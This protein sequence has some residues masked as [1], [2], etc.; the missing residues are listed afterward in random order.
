MEKHG[1]KVP[2]S[3]AHAPFFETF[4]SVQWQYFKDHPER[5][6]SFNSFM[7]GQ[8]QGRTCWLDIYPAE[9]RLIAEI[10]KEDDAVLLVDV[11]GGRGHDLLELAK[12]KGTEHGRLILQDLPEVVADAPELNAVESMGYDFFTPQPVKGR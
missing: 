3:S 6:Q 2:N 8:Q 4:G 5:G 11:G 12:R 10:T 7:Q 9:E 1:Y